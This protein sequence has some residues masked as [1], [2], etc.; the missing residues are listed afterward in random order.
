MLLAC[1]KVNWMYISYR[2]HSYSY[3]VVVLVWM[4]G[5]WK[6]EP[7][8]MT[9][10]HYHHLCDYTVATGIILL[11][12]LA[13]LK[14]HRV[15]AI[16]LPAEEVSRT[17]KSKTWNFVLLMANLC[18]LCPEHFWP[19]GWIWPIAVIIKNTGIC[20]RSL[21]GLDGGYQSGVT[22]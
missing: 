17:T 5:D 12:H 2:Y 16:K 18:P 6:M 9:S 10:K 1:K 11:L 3:H 13:E 8:I 15:Y 7:E 4:C 22:W 20:W 14:K 19:T 21:I